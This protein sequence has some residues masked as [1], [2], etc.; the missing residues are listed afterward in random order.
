M[1]RMRTLVT[2]V[3]CPHLKVDVSQDHALKQCPQTESYFGNVNP[4]GP[5]SCYDEGSATRWDV[6]EDD[7][8]H[9]ILLCF[10]DGGSAM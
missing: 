9:C 4:F 7:F 6:V 3:S 1:G 5:R 8:G 10:D 2:G